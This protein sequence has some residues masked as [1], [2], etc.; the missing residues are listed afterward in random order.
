VGHRI[1]ESCIR[2]GVLLDQIVGAP[3]RS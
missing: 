2:R 1:L 3:R